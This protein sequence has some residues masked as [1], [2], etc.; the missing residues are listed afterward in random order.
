ME[1]RRELL[2]KSLQLFFAELVGCSSADS[3]A[4]FFLNEHLTLN[5]K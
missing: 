4:L 3:S 2:V 1:E 5:E